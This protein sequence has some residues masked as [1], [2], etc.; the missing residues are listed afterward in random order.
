MRKKIKSYLVFT[1]LW[2]RFGVYLAIPAVLA[3]IGL[4]I[5]RGLPGGGLIVISVLLP[6][7]EIISDSWL[8]GGI[9]TKDSMKL[10]YLKT[11]GQGKELIRT[12]LWTDLFRKL[13]SAIVIMALFSLAMV[14]GKGEAPE[15]AGTGGFG[16]LLYLV[17]LS[18]L[19]SVLGTFVSRYASLV[20]INL[21]VSYGAM[22]L[23]MLCIFLLRLAEHILLI[24]LLFAIFGILMS[25]VAVKAAVE[26]VERSYHDE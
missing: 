26:R 18:W 15:A 12:A 10:E 3:A 23:A 2:Y 16:S 9:Q 21:I 24:D 13:L 8:F 19:V 1:S 20:W 11:S 4:L 25:T 22:V 14:M 7:A 6:V 5:E 17:L